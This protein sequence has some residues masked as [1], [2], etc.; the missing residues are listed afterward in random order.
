MKLP[1]RRITRQLVEADLSARNYLGKK[2]L[3]VDDQSFNIDASLIILNHAVG[4]NTEA[5]CSI[6][7]NGK[8]AVKMV[9]ESYYA[10]N[11]R[12]G[13]ELILMDCNMPFLDGYEATSQIRHFLFL[14]QQRQPIIVACTGHT[15]QTYIDKAIHSGMNKVMSKPLDPQ[16]LKKVVQFVRLI[17]V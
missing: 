9:Q 15:E 1:D 7:Y 17:A 5:E 6:A 3:I 2:I 12:N 14:K 11:C 8:E 4:I 10:N 13:Y 16:I